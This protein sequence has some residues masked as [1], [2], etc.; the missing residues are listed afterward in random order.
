M[1][2]ADLFRLL[3]AALLLAAPSVYGQWES[4]LQDGRRIEVDPRSNR[5]TVQSPE[6]VVTPLWDGVHRLEDGSTVIVREGLMVPN[7]D[8]LRLRREAP[9]QT[10]RQF[11]V[12]RASPCVTLVRK[13]CGLYEECAAQGACSHA[14]QLRAIELEEQREHATA[15]SGALMET[16]SQCAEALQDEEF[17]VPCGLRRRERSE[18]SCQRLVARVCGSRNQCG[19]RPGCPLAK[20]LMDMEHQERLTSI[21]AEA[22]TDAGRHCRDVSTDREIFA[23]CTP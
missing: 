17:F 4:R 3:F 16:P 6:G 2:R 15:Y 7:I 20:Q 13:V 22:I 1:T 12:Q 11:V 21:N 19:D 23:P 9:G 10:G 5:A 14:K 8:I 18:T